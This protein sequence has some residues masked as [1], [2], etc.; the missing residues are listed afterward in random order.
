M[1]VFEEFPSYMNPSSNNKCTPRA[2]G[3]LGQVRLM[4]VV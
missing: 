4:D 2:G 3:L 1:Y